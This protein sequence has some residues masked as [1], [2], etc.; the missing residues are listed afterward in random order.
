MKPFYISHKLNPATGLY[1]R[2]K[3]FKRLPMWLRLLI[4]R[5]QM[6][7]QPSKNGCI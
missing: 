1:D 2:R 5:Y 6:L 4:V 7:L 3:M